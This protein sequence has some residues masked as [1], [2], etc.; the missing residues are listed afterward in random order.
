VKSDALKAMRRWILVLAVTL[1]FFYTLD[2]FL[3]SAQGLPLTWNMA[4]GN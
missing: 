2:H 1:A 4:P 3:M